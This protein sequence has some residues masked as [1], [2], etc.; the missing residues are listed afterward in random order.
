MVKQA[1]A[2]A[3]DIGMP[4]TDNLNDDELA[5]NQFEEDWFL[6]GQTF[7]SPLASVGESNDEDPQGEDT[8]MPITREV[9][10]L[11]AAYLLSF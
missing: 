7:P 4:S 1:I 3:L 6:L 10:I 8:V 2:S 11:C 5:R 9:T